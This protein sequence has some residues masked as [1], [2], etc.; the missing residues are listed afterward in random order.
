MIAQGCLREDLPDPLFESESTEIQRDTEIECEPYFVDLTTLPTD[1]L[2]RLRET[3]LLPESGL[4]I[5]LL[6]EKHVDY[7]SQVWLKSLGGKKEHLF[8]LGL[9]CLRYEFIV[10][11]QKDSPL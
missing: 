6:A 3:G 9:R 11:Q 10:G 1:Q 7:L 5:Q 4:D 8:P 2:M